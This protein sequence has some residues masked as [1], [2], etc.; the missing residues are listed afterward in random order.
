MKWFT[1]YYFQNM[2]AVRQKV[3]ELQDKVMVVIVDNVTSENEENSYE[4]I[5]KA[6]EYT[7]VNLK[8]SHGAS[9]ELVQA[10]TRPK[11]GEK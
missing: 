10:R 8:I 11:K 4:V 3:K 2:S 5:V 7:S 9:Y 6:L 1:I